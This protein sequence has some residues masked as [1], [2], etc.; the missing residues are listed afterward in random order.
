MDIRERILIACRDIARVKGFYNMNMDELAQQAGVS[1]KTVYRYF[2]SK[3]EIIGASMDAFMLQTGEA[4][5]DIMSRDDPL[6]ELV[7]AA[8]KHLF[9]HGQFIT[10]PAGLHDLRI[11]YPELWQ[12]IDAFRMERIGGIV[13]SFIQQGNNPVLQDIDP[14]I[15]TQVILASVHTVLSP[16]FILDNGL[17]FESAAT[18]LIKFLFASFY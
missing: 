13:N 1:K 11:Y 3:E 5:D 16:D 15:I 10:N 14:R 8:M 7:A 12:K 6:P 2:R 4:I 18:Q 17:S 9:T